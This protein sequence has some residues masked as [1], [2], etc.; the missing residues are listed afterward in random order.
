MEKDVHTGHRARF[1]DRYRKEGVDSF[2]DHEL[3][4]MILYFGIPYRNTNETA[5]LLL[6]KFGSL[7][8]VLEATFEDLITV[9][10]VGENTATLINFIPDISRRY[11][12]DKQGSNKVFTE[13]DI[14]E[15]CINH[16]IGAT[17]EHTEMLLFDAKMHMIGHVK[18]FDGTLCA[19][20][21]TPEKL[22]EYIYSFRACN[23]V[24]TH[25]HPGGNTEPSYEDLCVTREVYLVM[26]AMNKHMTEHFI[27]TDGG[28][29][30]ILGDALALYD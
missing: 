28:C 19:S 30:A 25:N 23:F 7:S 29:R 17:S 10:G 20:G 9:K 16:F 18:V 1:K 2:Q 27:V 12:M 22:G 13:E 14:R 8:G 15:Y 26:K 24:L 6:N 3:L 4:E 21:V 5:H 11:I